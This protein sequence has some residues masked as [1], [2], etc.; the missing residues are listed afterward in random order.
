MRE[1]RTTG[2]GRGAPPADDLLSSSV[3][4]LA[5]LLDA[6]IAP[7]SAWQHAGAEA[8]HPAIV[9]VAALIGAGTPPAEALA[10]AA[11][12]GDGGG[13]AAIAAAWDV[14]EQAGAALAPA[15][16]GAA[17]SLRDRADAERDVATALAGP[18]ATARLMAWLPVV[19]VVMAYVIGVDVVG[20]LIGGPLGWA[21]AIGGAVLL[22]GGR[23]WTRRLLRDAS[24]SGPVA[25]A[26]H[27]LV[28]IALAGGLSASA[29]CAI[30]ED[31]AHRAGLAVEVTGDGSVARVLGIAERAGAPAIELL[32]AEARQERRTARADGRRKAELLAVRLLLPLGVCVLPAFVLLGVVPVVLAMMSSTFAGLG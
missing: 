25:G 27:D 6:G 18:R 22:L 9:R 20:A 31:A 12:R 23:A 30:A 8:R 4:A 1:R 19:G 7:R 10:A 14:A 5:V 13:L 29:A 32:T 24:R 3:E 26:G 28:A 2:R 11:V 15:L 16:R 17:E 21:A